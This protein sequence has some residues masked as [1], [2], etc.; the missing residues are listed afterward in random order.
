MENFYNIL[1]VAP[2]ATTEE[3]KERYRFLA[4]AYHPDKFAT[5]GHKKLAEEQFKKINEAYQILA[6]PTKREQY[7]NEFLRRTPAASKGDQVQHQQE[8]RKKA[9][10]LCR[11]EYERQQRIYQIDNEISALNHDIGKLKQEMPNWSLMFI[12]LLIIGGIYILPLAIN[13][14]VFLMA[15]GISIIAGLGLLVKRDTFYRNN[16][17]PMLDEIE[18]RKQHLY[19]IV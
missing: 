17:K 12:L 5:L 13:S 14:S 8:N 7:N 9:E 10:N 4:Q 1:G 19:K 6:D 15:G 3:T 11:A 18:K 2:N 16:Y